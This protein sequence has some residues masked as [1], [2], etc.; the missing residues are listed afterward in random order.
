MTVETPTQQPNSHTSLQAVLNRVVGAGGA[1]GSCP[2]P[3][4]LADQLILS[5]GGGHIMP[6]TLLLA[7]QILRPSA[8]PVQ[9]TCIIK[10]ARTD[11]Y[12]V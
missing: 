9:Y 1:G 10:A 4:I 8:I 11:W 12:S 6:T 7:P 5:R 2:P 3:Q